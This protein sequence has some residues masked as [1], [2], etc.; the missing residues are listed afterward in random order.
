MKKLLLVA[1][2]SSAI[3]S[4]TA[5]AAAENTFYLKANAGTNKM[6]KV[7][8]DDLKLKSKFTPVVDLGVGYY[9]MD[10]LRT[11]LTLGFVFN[12]EQKKNFEGDTYKSKA[13]IQTLMIRLI[14]LTN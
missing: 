1:A 3:L 10:N 12:P 9:I 8:Y 4:S 5:F 6:Q 13:N 14:L 7:K 11:D 2:T